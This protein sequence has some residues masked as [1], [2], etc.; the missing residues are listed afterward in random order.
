MANPASTEV[1]YLGYKY[2]WQSI[3]GLIPSNTSWISGNTSL[4]IGTTDEFIH[5]KFNIVSNIQI[6]AS[7]TYSSMLLISIQRLSSNENDTYKTNKVGGTG[8]ANLGL[9]YVDIHYQKDRLGSLLE[10]SDY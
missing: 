6:P 4:S 7:E 1:V 5:K 10:N 9:L 8:K 2:T 3:G